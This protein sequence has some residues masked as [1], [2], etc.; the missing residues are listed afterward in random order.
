MKL[1]V[2]RYSSGKESTLG[3]LFI[4]GEF[5]CY[6]LED[7]YRSQKVYSE[8]RIPDGE[9]KIGLKEQGVF[10]DKYIKKFPLSHR[11][12]LHI[13]DVPNFSDVLIHIGNNDD[14]TAGCLLLGDGANNNKVGSG[15]ISNS[16]VAYKRVYAKVITP[17]LNGEDVTISYASR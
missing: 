2:L 7:E 15:F 1:E 14:D 11:G 10:H 12:M 4:N 13:L 9:Y 8:T 5:E 6:T 17:L 16:T 3:L